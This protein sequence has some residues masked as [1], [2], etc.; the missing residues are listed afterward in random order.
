MHVAE[1]REALRERVGVPRLVA[2]V[3]LLDDPLSDEIED[4]EQIASAPVA[5]NKSE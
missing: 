2:E 4:C 5:L 3:E 1:V